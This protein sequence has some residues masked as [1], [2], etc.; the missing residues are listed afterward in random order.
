MTGNRTTEH[1]ASEL[2]KALLDERGADYRMRQSVTNG[3]MD[4]YDRYTVFIDGN[5]R[6]LIDTGNGDEVVLT[7][8]CTPEQAVAATLGEQRSTAEIAELLDE[9]ESECFMLRVEASET[10]ARD[11]VVRESYGRILD[12]FAGRIAATVGAGECELVETESYSNANE[13]IH[14]LECSA[15]GKTCEHVNGSYPRCP[16]CG[17][18]AV[19]R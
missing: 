14:V 6:A 19:K 13:V 10:R 16:H 7:L 12:E 9:F 15:C 4:Y 2:V 11:D 5:P 8:R 1:T 17:R 18:K 3:S